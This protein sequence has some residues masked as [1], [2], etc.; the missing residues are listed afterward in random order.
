MIKSLKSKISLVYLALVIISSLVGITSALSLVKLSGSIEGL[1]TA[2]YKSI[3][4]LNNMIETI[5]QQNSAI[6]I[7]ISTNRQK[8][9]DMFSQNNNSFTQWFDVART[10]ITEVGEKELIENTNLHYTQYIRSFLQ[11][12]EIRN[13]SGL[14]NAIT[15]YNETITPEFNIIK[16]SLSALIQLN[17]K[18]MFKGKNDANNDARKFI[19]VVLILTS[20]ATIGGFIISRY[21]INRFLKPIYTLTQTVKLVKAGGLNLQATVTSKDEIG[22]LS[23]EFNNMTKRLLQFEQSAL[24]NLMSEK[25]RFI[26]VVKNIA[27]PLLVMDNSYK[28]AILNKTCESFFNITEEKAVNKHFLEVIRNGELFD[29]ISGE[30]SLGEDRKEK[31]I[32]V[33]SNDEEYYLNVVVTI[34]KDVENNLTGLIVLFHNVT[35]LKELEK[36][37]TDFIATI[38]HEFKTPLTSIMM[39]TDL[40]LNAGIGAL[41]DDQKSIT[42]ALKEDCERLSTLVNDIMEL[43]K[44]ESSKAIFKIEPC[45]IVGIIESTY[46]QFNQIAEQKSVELEFDADENLPPVSAD[47]EKIKWVLNNLVSNALKYTNA[48]DD[49]LISASVKNNKMYISVKDTGVGI[50]DE[51]K[52]NIFDKFFQVKG[53]DLEIRG[54]GLGLSV[55]KEIIQAHGGK[56]WCE[57]KLDLGSTFSFTLNLSK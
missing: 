20:L 5:E 38:S 35:A 36:I 39:G 49:I 3:N 34:V 55:A 2:N 4:A 41:N 28:I 45:T 44:I 42:T 33:K 40:L 37:R 6:L 16:G 23:L 25:K 13:T 8:G 30:F 53:N 21:F 48:G 26:A 27:D 54:T 1:M 14:E 17:E 31:I 24:G 29:H 52:E 43:T 47:F 7:Y 12:Q 22:E 32:H 11:L 18:A 51:Y 46:K 57:S 10:N 19:Y 56:I 50:P 9:L 15:Y